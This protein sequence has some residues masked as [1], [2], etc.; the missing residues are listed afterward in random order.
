M[1]VCLSVSVWNTPWRLDLC[2]ATSPRTLTST[3]C[4]MWSTLPTSSTWCSLS[5]SSTPSVWP[6]RWVTHV[7]Q[8][9]ALSR[10]FS[11]PGKEKKKA[12]WKCSAFIAVVQIHT[13]KKSRGFM[14]VERKSQVKNYWFWN[15]FGYNSGF[16][17]TN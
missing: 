16:M 15:N 7:H 4:G 17:D 2:V 10:V 14:Q 5:S 13:N 11:K 3:R 9:S 1:D 12:F 6:C 8:H